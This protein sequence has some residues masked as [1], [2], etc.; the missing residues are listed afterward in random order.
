MLLQRS[1]S[2]DDESYGV[3]LNGDPAYDASPNS[4]KLLT[5][6]FN[7]YPNTNVSAFVLFEHERVSRLRYGDL[8]VLNATFEPHSD[9]L[10][11][12]R[13]IPTEGQV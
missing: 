10:I 4:F 3:A 12:F 11:Q 5:R 13:Q 2:A 7:A 9:F 8:V 6:V 1:A